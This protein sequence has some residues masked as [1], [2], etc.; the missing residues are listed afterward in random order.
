MTDVR[1]EMPGVVCAIKV[2]EGQRVEQG[3]V[4][5]ILESMKM[6]VPVLAPVAGEVTILCDG[7]GVRS[8]RGN[9]DGRDPAA[10]LMWLANSVPM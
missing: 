6:E 2:T 9:G 10:Y 1:A 8:R 4:L 7:I 5:L 3:D